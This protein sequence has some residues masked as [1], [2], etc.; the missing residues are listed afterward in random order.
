MRKSICCFIIGYMALN[1]KK[2]PTETS[3]KFR[4]LL[5]EQIGNEFTA[6]QQYTAIAV[7]YDSRDLPR[8]AAHFYAQA[9][10]E[11]NHAMML[12]KY[13]LD[14]DVPVTIP[15]VGEVRNDF[16][17]AR[18]PVELALAQ[19]KTV[20]EQIVALAKAARDEGDYLGEQ[21]LQWFLKEQVEEVSSMSTLLTVVDRADGNLFHVENFVA[22]ELSG[23]GG[24]DPTAPAAAGGAL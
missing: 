9:L 6:S 12:V 11:R 3:S 5:Q 4:A 21:F 15:G 2:L 10:E 23:A 24:D 7:W 17:S 20:T 14:T 16:G 13:L 19:E 1:L 18:E 22:R 8:L